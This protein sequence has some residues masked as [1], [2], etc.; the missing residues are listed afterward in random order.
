MEMLCLAP[1]YNCLIT[2]NEIST[3]VSTVCM[4]VVFSPLFSP[5]PYAQWWLHLIWSDKSNVINVFLTFSHLLVELATGRWHI[6]DVLGGRQVSGD[7]ILILFCV[8]LVIHVHLA[9]ACGHHHLKQRQKDS[10]EVKNT[11]CFASEEENQRHIQSL[12][13]WFTLVFPVTGKGREICPSWQS[14]SRLHFC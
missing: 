4:H 2:G 14:E 3:C 11:I 7:I 12:S 8:P 1:H 5:K 10:Y 13:V 6:I 9:N